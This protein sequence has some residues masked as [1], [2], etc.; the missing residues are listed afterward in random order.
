ML[1]LR[2]P[3]TLE[4]VTLEDEYYTKRWYIRMNE[5]SENEG[6]EYVCTYRE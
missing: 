6:N 3:N 4:R 1:K 5:K 2:Y